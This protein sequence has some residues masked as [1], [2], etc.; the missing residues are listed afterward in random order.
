MAASM[1]SRPERRTAEDCPGTWW[2]TL[3]DLVDRDVPDL[4]R[5]L[6]AAVAEKEGHPA[7]LSQVREVRIWLERLHHHVRSM[8]RECR[9][10]FPWLLPLIQPP[11]ALAGLATAIAAAVPPTLRLG[12]IADRCRQARDLVK[13][14]VA[15]QPPVDDDVLHVWSDGTVRRPRSGRAGG[16]ALCAFRS[17]RSQ[18]VPRTW[19]S[20]WSSACCT[21]RICGCSTSATT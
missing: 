3:R 4:D 16:G 17:A 11:P 8:D 20:R 12:E 18:R 21:T 14:A 5:Q 9:S 19:P 10:L 15:A 6:L 7:T 1:L 2:A 13:L